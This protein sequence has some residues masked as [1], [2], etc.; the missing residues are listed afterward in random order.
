MEQINEK[1]A[2]L[3]EGQKTIIE[4]QQKTFNFL[5]QLADSINVQH[6]EIMN[7]FKT[8]ENEIYENRELI[9]S[10]WESK[11]QSCLEIIKTRLRMDIYQD[12]LPKH[13]ALLQ[14]YA[15]IDG[16]GAVLSH[17]AAYIASYRFASDKSKINP[18]FSA[19]ASKDSFKNAHNLE[20]L[21]LITEQSFKLFFQSKEFKQSK[22]NRNILITA[23][24]YPSPN[25]NELNNKFASTE[26]STDDKNYKSEFKNEYF[27][28]LLL[29]QA[30][31]RH[32]FVIRNMNYLT[33]ISD[34]KGNL[35]NLNKV[36]D[37]NFILRDLKLELNEAIQLNN[38]AIAQQTML[39]G[40]ILLPI[41]Y[42]ILE[43]EKNDTLLSSKSKD[44]LKRNATLATNFTNYYFS[45]RTNSSSLN[46]LQYAFAYTSKDSTLFKIIVNPLFPV[47]YI[48]PTDSR[49]KTYNIKEGWHMIISNLPYRIPEPTLIDNISLVQLE[50]LQI[51]IDNRNKSYKQLKSYSIYD[52]LSPD[53]KTDLN[54]IIM[55][56]QN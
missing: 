48:K 1:L 37:E 43:I 47:E 45:K 18:N 9:T 41:I 54:Y 51:L 26:V 13:D 34:G 3:I 2:I 15:N 24:F 39:S 7:E 52:G 49:I 55:K 33:N 50:S 27:L 6:N 29:P 12:I 20:E 53:Q 19:I 31:E 14:E 23:L 10:N 25:I 42:D 21:Q 4:N 8:V 30:I 22:E 56:T 35:I 17:C 46:L 16:E 5:I 36:A 32:G 40:D 44:L 38:I 28:K 11:C